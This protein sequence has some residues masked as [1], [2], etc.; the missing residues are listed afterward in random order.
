MAKTYSP[1]IEVTRV[2]EVEGLS[3][4]ALI[5]VDNVNLVQC[6]DDGRAKIYFI[7]GST[8]TP[9]FMIPV[10]NY[11]DIVKLLTDPEVATLPARSHE[12]STE[13]GERPMTTYKTKAMNVGDFT[14]TVSKAGKT[15]AERVAALIEAIASEIDNT[16][17]GGGGGPD[18]SLPGAGAG[19]GPRPDQ[20]LP[21]Q[22]GGTKPVD[23]DEGAPDQGLPGQE[24]SEFLK[25]N[26][27]EIAKAVLKGTLCDPEAQPKR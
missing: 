27:D 17:P 3:T 4:A 22:G 12:K 25:E 24:L 16:L 20:G 23:P 7:E 8:N 10:E 9:Q 2:D 14:V 11:A 18:Q 21:G 5:N 1:F 15:G 19:G 13:E 26:A 6:L